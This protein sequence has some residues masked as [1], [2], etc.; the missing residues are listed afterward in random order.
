MAEVLRN[1]VVNLKDFAQSQ[2]GIQNREKLHAGK[3]MNDVLTDLLGGG[4]PAEHDEYAEEKSGPENEKRTVFSK[5]PKT[6]QK[7]ISL[8]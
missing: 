2:E 5:L 6:R 1:E 8:S 4:D 3:D 7:K